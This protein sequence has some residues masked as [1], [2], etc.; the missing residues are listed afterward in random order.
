MPPYVS[1]DYYL[2]YS[3]W[4]QFLFTID[5]LFSGLLYFMVGVGFSA[6]YNDNILTDLDRTKGIF[7]NFVETMALML[8]TIAA[9]YLIIH[10]MPKIPSLVPNPPPEHLNFRLRG[11]DIILA[12]GV[13]SCQLLYLDKIRYLYNELKDSSQVEL[14][15]IINNYKICHDGSVVPAGS[16]AC[17]AV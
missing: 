5:I 15:N 1:A 2:N 4:K 12:F 13:V 6:W 7:L 14:S 10:F 17:T 9:I 16:F 8:I 3:I 11:T